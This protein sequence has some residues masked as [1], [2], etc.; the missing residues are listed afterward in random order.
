MEMGSLGRNEITKLK[1]L[2]NLKDVQRSKSILFR[3]V[4]NNPSL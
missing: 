3:Y 1:H 2:T 4:L